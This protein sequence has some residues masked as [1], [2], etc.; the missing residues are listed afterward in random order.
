MR[1]DSSSY[2]TSFNT[3]LS[4]TNRKS[5]VIP[6]GCAHGFQTLSDDCQLLYFHTA[7]YD[8]EAEYGINSLDS[9]LGIKWPLE[10]TFRSKKDIS[11]PFI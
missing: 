7:N 8:P 4:D 3:I 10:I 2:L 5:M 11:L 6:E 9:T 1:E